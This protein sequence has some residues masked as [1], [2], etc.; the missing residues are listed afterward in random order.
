MPILS[1]LFIALGLAMD[2]FAVSI[3]SGITI[4][5]V[6]IRQALLIAT[7]FG[8]FQ[9][10]MPVLGWWLGQWAYRFI[11]AVDYWIAFA[12]LLFVGGHMII[13]A[14]HP[15]EETDAKSPLHIPTLLMLAIAT[16]IDAFAI[17][18]SLSM[19][20]VSIVQPVLIIGLVTFVLS[21]AGVYFGRLFGHLSEKKME[22]AGGLVLIGLGV[23]ILIEHLMEHQELFNSKTV[24]IAFGL[25][26]AAGLGTGV[27]GLIT[28]FSRNSRPRRLSFTLGLSA[29]ALLWTAFHELLPSGGSMPSA[30][31]A[32]FAG[33]ILSALIDRLVPSF[34]NPH[35]PLR[36]E[37]LNKTPKFQRTGMPALLAISLHSFPEGIALF[38]AALHAPFAAAVCATLGLALHNIPEG[39]STAL[40][41]YHASG[42]R[43][44]ACGYS[45]L[46]GLAEPLSALVF[47]TLFHRLI[48][49]AALG[50]LTAAGAGVFVF[51]ALDGLLPAAR[52]YGKYHHAVYGVGIGMLIAMGLT[53]LIQ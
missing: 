7:C 21:F 20:R 6:K 4:K 46:T 45:S 1:I 53:Q 34:G 31:L 10:V 51:I 27:G 33:F 38:V 50:G 16:S 42:S 19:L 40:P 43:A 52:T 36:V 15:E 2:A 32:F 14:M 44:K 26:L 5:R 48:I 25:T 11:S 22:V 9:A 8:V 37:E 17:G 29:G 49:P 24:L 30:T 23:K 13:V 35:E 3:T 41:M 12:L 28:L 39:L 18:I 47:Y